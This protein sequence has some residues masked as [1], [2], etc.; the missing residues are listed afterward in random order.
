[1][2]THTSVVTALARG[3]WSRMIVQNCHKQP[4]VSGPSIAELARTRG[5]DAFDVIYDILLGEGDDLHSVLVLGFVYTPEDTHLAFEHPQCMIGSDATALSA[6]RPLGSC[7]VHGAFTWASWFW[8]HFVRDTHK[9]APEEAVRRM[10]SLPARRV[11]LRGRGVLEQGAWADVVVFDP[12]HF[13]ERGTIAHPTQT[14]T[15]TRYVFVNGELTLKDGEPT[16]LRPGR[17]LRLHD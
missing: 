1:M 16:G 14:A 15:G 17:V 3:D 9:L 10:T 13:A 5:C 7:L 6:D 12:L 2:K 8:R 4:E 11:G